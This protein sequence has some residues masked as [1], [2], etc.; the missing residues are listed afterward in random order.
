M[1]ETRLALL[2][3]LSEMHTQPIQYNLATLTAIV[4]QIAPDFLCLELPRNEWEIG[5]LEQAPVEV[6]RSM[7]PLAAL[8]DV[9]VV[10]VAPDVRQ[11][12]DFA[13]KAG[14][15]AE[16]AQQLAG[17]LRRAQRAANNV[18]AIHAMFFQSV[19]HALCLLNEMSWDAEARRAWNEQN[20]GLLD[21]VLQAARRDP[22]RRMLVAVQC[23][24]VHW[25]DPR[26]KRVPDVE[27]VDYR[28]L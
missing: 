17:A 26:L 14:W 25:L 12:N 5:N 3:T 13:P 8:S 9:V 19:C 7:L 24:R 16:V 2:S 15:R 20:Q 4:N 6:R 1:T 11:F 21:N 22:G 27:L 10:P 23:Q 28:M 18:E